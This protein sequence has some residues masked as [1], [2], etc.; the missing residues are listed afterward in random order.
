M[1]LFLLVILLFLPSFSHAEKNDTA[2]FLLA[3]EGADYLQKDNAESYE[4]ARRLCE[5]SLVA[6]PAYAF[7]RACLGRSY[8]KMGKMGTAYQHYRTALLIN[9]NNLEASIWSGEIDMARGDYEKAYERF[10]DLEELC[11]RCASPLESALEGYAAKGVAPRAITRAPNRFSVPE[12]VPAKDTKL[13]YILI[14]DFGGQFTQLIAR[15]VRECEVCC[16]IVP[17]DRVE[18]QILRQ[19]PHGMILSGGPASLQD[20]DAPRIP[21]KLFEMGIPSLGICYGQQLLS[22]SLGG[23]VESS[24]AGEFGRAQI[25]VIKDSPLFKGLEKAKHQVWMSHGDRV[26][27]LPQGFEVLASSEHAP[28]AAIGDDRR[29]LYGVQFHPEVV[30]TPRG[31]EMLEN[32]VI[33]ISKCP[34][35]WNLQNI[36]TQ[37]LSALRAQI[38]EGRVLCALSGGVDSA[39][40]AAL[41]HEAVGAQLSCIFVDTGL[42]RKGEAREVSDL[43]REHFNIPLIV[44]EAEETFLRSLKGVTDPEK[45]RKVIGK[46]FIDLFEEEAKKIGRVEFLAQGTLYPDVI[47][48][49]SVKGAPS[50][51]IKSHHNVGGL[52]ERM[53]L[54]LVE[55]LR[56]LFKDEVRALGAIIKMPKRFLMRHPFP[57]PGLAVRIPGEIT[58]EKCDILRQADAIYME[59]IRHAHL[60]DE[61]WQAFA[62]LLPVRSVGVMGDAR[63]Y[64]Y[65]C[66]LRAVTSEDGMTADVYPFSPDFLSR[67]STR[68][69]NEV[70]GINR[71]VYDI[72]SKP[73]ASIEWE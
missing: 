48:S 37:T 1:P 14:A 51:T 34:R 62:V 45:K 57:G 56:S 8:Q 10:R 25:K 72:T 22:L 41:I 53:A 21:P 63:S 29:R 6:D 67:V 2:S 24:D 42:L 26:S 40:T 44:L 11:G 23:G 39:V 32:F 50:R 5:L 28:W 13:P 19:K 54:K 70:K 16:E 64:D 52:P 20:Q 46:T 15:R 7:A 61:I 36:R 3:K 30:H 58:K 38:G 43:F 66:A 65:V 73:P 47:E 49:V 35:K 71:V 12:S 31:K 33:G 4:K 18:A 60:Y 55:P 9:P 17:Y 69:V 59:E 68:I 27:K